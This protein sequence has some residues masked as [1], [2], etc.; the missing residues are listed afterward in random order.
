MS[1]DKREIRKPPPMDD[2]KFDD[3]WRSFGNNDLDEFEQE[4]EASLKDY[5]ILPDPN[6]E[7]KKRRIQEMARRARGSAYPAG[8]T[9]E[10]QKLF[11]PGLLAYWRGEAAT[12]YDDPTAWDEF[13]NNLNPSDDLWRIKPAG[14]ERDTD[15]QQE[16]TEGTPSAEDNLG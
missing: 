4:I 15:H 10:Q 2:A 8:L 7:E 6:W 9:E 13:A 5:E 16:R 3:W 1:D 14:S 11:P 12:P